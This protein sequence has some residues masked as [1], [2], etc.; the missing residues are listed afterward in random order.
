MWK[1]AIILSLAAM[2]LSS[3]AQAVEP[4]ESPTVTFDRE[5]AAYSSTR[6]NQLL[7][8]RDLN[9]MPEYAQSI[10]A[11]YVIIQGAAPIFNDQPVA[12]L[13]SDY[14][15][16]LTAYGLTLTPEAAAEIEAAGYVRV[17]GDE[18]FFSESGAELYDRWEWQSILGAYAR[19]ETEEKA[20]TDGMVGTVVAVA[21]VEAD[22]DGDGVADTRDECQDTPKGVKANERGC[23]EF[24]SAV[25]FE[26][27]K[28]VVSPSYQAELN[29]VQTILA[30]N[31]GLKIVVEGHTCNLGRSEYNKNLSEK[32]AKAV[33]G[34][35]VDEA[36][37]DSA[38]VMWVGFGEERPAYSND[39]EEGRAKNRRVQFKRWQ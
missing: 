22:G 1:N 34:Y 24:S 13:P 18:L 35:L 7:E 31:P 32:R 16:I 27:D 8:A 14:H 29:E 11:S 10:P 38:S 17:V 21:V 37:V 5:A 33:V 36:G 28:A 9:F 4:P 26:L 30:L 23:W 19:V 12:Y 2:L 6:F 15:N 3:P 20:E 25:L 39:T